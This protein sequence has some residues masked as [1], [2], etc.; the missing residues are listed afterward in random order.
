MPML[1]LHTSDERAEPP[2]RSEREDRDFE[3]AVAG[4]VRE[5]AARDRQRIETLREQWPAWPEREDRD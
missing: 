3:R 1:L 4:A 2:R 5:R